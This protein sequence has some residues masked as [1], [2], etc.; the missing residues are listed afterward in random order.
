MLNEYIL[1]HIYK[2]DA[3]ASIYYECITYLQCVLPSVSVLKGWEVHASIALSLE[4]EKL[5]VVRM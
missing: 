5:I 1:S 3:Y 2:H 4:L